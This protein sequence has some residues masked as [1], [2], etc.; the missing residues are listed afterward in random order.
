[1]R[2]H[3]PSLV[4]VELPAATGRAAAARVFR[5]SVL[6]LPN[7]GMA[8][9]AVL[10]AA[11]GGPPRRIVGYASDLWTRGLPP[12]R[13]DEHKQGRVR[14]AASLYRL[15]PSDFGAKT[16]AGNVAD[17][18]LLGR[19]ALCREGQKQLFRGGAA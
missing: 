8:V 18:V 13:H 9:G 10:A 16:V 1:V 11:V 12:T 19:Y 7:Y 4:A 6:T 17:A 2:E 3:A 15:N 14:L 5:T